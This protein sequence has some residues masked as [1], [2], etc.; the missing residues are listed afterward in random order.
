MYIV[1]GSIP[2]VLL[3][4]MR[5]WAQPRGRTVFIAGTMGQVVLLLLVHRPGSLSGFLNLP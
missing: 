1:A 3:H 4:E 2:E 5:V